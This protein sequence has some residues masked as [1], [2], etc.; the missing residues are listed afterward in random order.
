MS[1][2]I[3]PFESPTSSALTESSVPPDSGKSSRG[4][5]NLVCL[6]LCAIP[7]AVAVFAWSVLFYGF[8]T[9]DMLPAPKIWPIGD[10]YNR[11]NTI[12]MMS[13]ALQAT[14]ITGYCITFVGLG[15]G[16]CDYVV[17]RRG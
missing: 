7:A 16:V 9:G 3:N 17:R 5:A 11:G 1:E 14:L 2:K 10:S 4:I 13:F 12:P 6:V 15:W 8:L